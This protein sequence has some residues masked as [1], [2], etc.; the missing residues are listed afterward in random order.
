MSR[1][2]LRNLMRGAGAFLWE[3]E[4]NSSRRVSTHGTGPIRGL[5]TDR[6]PAGSPEDLDC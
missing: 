6:A 5:L 2:A 1:Q 3:A 4:G